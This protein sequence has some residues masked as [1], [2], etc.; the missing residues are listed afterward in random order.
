MLRQVPLFIQLDILL[1]L[2]QKVEL[3]WPFSHASPRNCSSKC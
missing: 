1:H 3:K 2:T